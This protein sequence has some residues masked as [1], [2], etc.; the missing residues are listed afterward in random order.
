MKSL[1]TN[2]PLNATI[3]IIL[4]RTYNHPSKIAPNIQKTTMKDLFLE[5]C[6]RMLRFGFNR[7]IYLFKDGVAM[8]TPLG[9][10]FADYMSHLEAPY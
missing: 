9:P 8:V 7:K 4:E 3:E 1:F 6:T 2:I 5:C 10:T